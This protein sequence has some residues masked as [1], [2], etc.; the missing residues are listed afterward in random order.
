MYGRVW[1]KSQPR[2]LLFSVQL[3]ISP[4]KCQNHRTQSDIIT[5]LSVPTF[6]LWY[7]TAL[8]LSQEEY[9]HRGVALVRCVWKLHFSKLNIARSL[10]CFNFN[11]WC[12]FLFHFGCVVVS[13]VGFSSRISLALQVV[14]MAQNYCF[15]RVVIL[16]Q[17]NVQNIQKWHIGSF[18][19]GWLEVRCQPHCS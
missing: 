15:C 14:W 7:L 4:D 10:F 17:E 9:C 18:I 6:K 13:A 2:N 5:L 16:T 11:F 12:N 19:L 1:L 3:H 8:N